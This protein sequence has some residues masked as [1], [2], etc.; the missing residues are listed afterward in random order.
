MKNAQ[1][2]IKKQAGGVSIVF[3]L[4]IG[5]SITACTVCV[6]QSV[7]NTQQINSAS[8]AITHAQNGTWSGVVAFQRYLDT[9]QANQLTNLPTEL[10]IVMN[11]QYGS[12][13]ARNITASPQADGSMNVVADIVNTHAAAK[14]SY[15]VRVVYGVSPSN[16]PPAPLPPVLGFEDS[17]D[18]SGSI[19]FTNSGMPVDIAVDGDIVIDGVGIS[20][21]NT[22]SSTG[23]VE[24]G[25]QVVVENVLANDDVTINSNDVATVRTTGNFTANGGSSVDNVWANGDV[26]IN[27]SGRFDT[28]SALGNISVTSGGAGQGTLTAAQMIIA[29]TG[30]ADHMRAVG[31]IDI[32]HWSTINSVISMGDISCVGT[33]WNNFTSLSANGNLLNCKT[34]VSAVSGASQT[35]MVMAPV[36]DVPEP[37]HVIDVWKM[38][39]QA[40][41]FVEWDASV[42]RIKVTVNQIN[43]IADGSEFYLGDYNASGSTPPYIGYLCESVNGSGKC[44]APSTPTLPLCFGQSLWQG[45]VTYNTGTD[46]WQ[47]DPSQTPPGVIMF[48]GNVRLVNR[49]AV[50]TILASG[51]IETGGGI[52]ITGVNYAGYDRV[53]TAEGSHVTS[54]SR[55]RYIESFTQYY[56]SNL[57]DLAQAKYL[58]S[59]VGNIGIAAGGF[60]PKDGG[61]VFSGGNIDLS[62]QTVISGAALAGN[63]IRTQ[64]HVTIRGLVLAAG[65]AEG[66]DGEN[67]L[68]GRTEI[69]LNSTGTYDPL[70]LP[71][72][73]DGPSL[74]A[75]LPQNVT[76]VLWVRAL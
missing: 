65:G 71:D 30:T 12:L 76:R 13:A 64:G 34:D 35:V 4:L 70:V 19:E 47:F 58:P 22:V 41:Y 32:N 14:S 27:A 46:T 17:L 59:V 7:K 60:H 21:L 48:D 50:S 25:S 68:S 18:L 29:N 26:L 57:C 49:E 20:P 36:Q 72:L 51:D 16:L 73:S 69:D 1:S 3:V 9:L 63:V 74:S 67:E 44:M 2:K 62:A 66:T 55:P 42:S 6:F 31:D 28:V 75:A 45:C 53:C 33:S 15:A 11:S 54:H 5:L 38:K 24:L 40:N 8:N 52:A 43:N 61:S 56:P 23:T 10:D 37:S 39:P